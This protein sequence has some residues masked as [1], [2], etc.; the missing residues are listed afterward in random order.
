MSLD[1]PVM[2]RMPQGVGGDRRR[3]PLLDPPVLE[4]SLPEPSAGSPVASLSPA[5]SSSVDSSG[6]PGRF[7]F[8]ITV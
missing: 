2:P 3:A 6:D 8:W 4:P 7:P 1:W 5:S